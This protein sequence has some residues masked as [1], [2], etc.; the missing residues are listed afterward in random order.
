H[1][2]LRSRSWAASRMTWDTFN[3]IKKRT[4]LLRPKLRLPYRELEVLAV[5]SG[6]EYF[7]ESQR[8][9]PDTLAGCIEHG[10]GDRGGD[11][12][13]ADLADAARPQGSARVG[14]IGPQHLELGDIEMHRH[15]ILGQ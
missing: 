15:M 1:R 12:G 3:Q 11:S 2:M 9:L 6:R 7:V 14:N 4:P 10:V 8:Q 5:L 13:D